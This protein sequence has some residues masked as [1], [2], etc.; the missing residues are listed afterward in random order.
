M[1]HAIKEAKPQK[2]DHTVQTLLH[3]LTS[4]NLDSA[5]IYETAAELLTNEQYAEICQEYSKQRNTFAD[6]L[7]HLSAKYGT[8]GP[9]EESFNGLM[10][11]AW[12]SLRNLVS[13]DDTAVLV[14][15]DR[16][17]EHAISVYLDAIEAD[18]PD[19]VETLIRQ[20]LAELKG[21]HERIHRLAAALQQN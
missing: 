12:M 18:L 1:N 9:D 17:D 19:D 15:C 14:E 20:Q 8:A 2:I 4:L 11:D 5:G 13:G 3:Q 16:S 10:Q 6:E 21:E 7:R